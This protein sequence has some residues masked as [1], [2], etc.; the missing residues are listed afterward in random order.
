MS[1]EFPHVTLPHPGR[2]NDLWD[3]AKAGAN[4]M[5]AER[6]PYSRISVFLDRVMKAHFD[7]IEPALVEARKWVNVE[8]E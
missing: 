3:W 1:V 2:P 5:R 6:I 4:A 8:P 7:G